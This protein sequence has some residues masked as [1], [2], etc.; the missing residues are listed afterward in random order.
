MH[1]A[2]PA[3][4][5]EVRTGTVSEVH[6]K[7]KQTNKQTNPGTNAPGLPGEDCC[8]RLGEGLSPQVAGA[9]GGMLRARGMSAPPARAARSM[10]H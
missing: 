10:L 1:P 6:P 5:G 9:E 4:I 3:L 7:E 2:P 8:S